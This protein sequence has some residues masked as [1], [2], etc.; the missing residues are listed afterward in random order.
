MRTITHSQTFIL[1]TLLCLA[2]LA[3]NTT[4]A[5]ACTPPPP[6]PWFVA[7][8]SLESTILPDH[9]SITLVDDRLELVNNTGS[10]I[11]ILNEDKSLEKISDKDLDIRVVTD[12]SSGNELLF[13]YEHRGNGF[14]NIP[15]K[16]TNTIADNR[17]ENAT[18]PAP[19]NVTVDLLIGQQPLTLQFKVTYQLNPAYRPDSVFRYENSCT[20]L[21]YFWA[22]MR[23]PF[24]FILAALIGIVL[25]L[26]IVLSTLLAIRK[27]KNSQ[28]Q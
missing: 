22:T 2:W 6:T 24:G 12:T 15:L 28:R 17:P 21:S 3:Y 8:P 23:D 1:A 26:I 18:A 11:Y 16:T 7:T 9:I 13:L 20:P 5:F 19:E 27:D 14:K 10:P 25:M 4:P